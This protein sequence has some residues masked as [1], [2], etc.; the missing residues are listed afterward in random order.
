M[1]TKHNYTN[2]SKKHANAKASSNSNSYAYSNESVNAS[3]ITRKTQTKLS[4]HCIYLLV[5]T[6]SIQLGIK[7]H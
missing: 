6:Y 5:K 7:Y 2:I 3:T 1:N 4:I